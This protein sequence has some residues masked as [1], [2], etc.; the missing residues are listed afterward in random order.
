MTD[1]EAPSIVQT[2]ECGELGQKRNAALHLHNRLLAWRDCVRL[3][4]NGARCHVFLRIVHGYST[5]R[6]EIL[7]NDMKAKPGLRARK[8]PKLKLQTVQ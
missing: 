7:E 3:Q 2:K 8:L 5:G 4:T 6:V 1:R